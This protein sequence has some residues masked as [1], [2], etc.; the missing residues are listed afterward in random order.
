MICKKECPEYMGL[1]CELNSDAL[2]V[3]KRKRPKIGRNFK[4]EQGV[5]IGGQPILLDENGEVDTDL[6]GVEIGDDVWIAA[7]SIVMSGKEN[8]TQIGNNVKIGTYCNIGHDAILRDN[9]KVLSGT[10]IAGYAVIG[11][12]VTLG[13]GSLIRNRVRIGE[14]S[15]IGMG[16]VVVEDIPAHCLAYGVPCKVDLTRS[17]KRYVVKKYRSVLR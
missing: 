14:G 17:L 8:P 2:V 6:R 1:G 13:M 11:K 10:M 12:G 3:C 4:A 16:S 5:I 9:V 15:F 7:M